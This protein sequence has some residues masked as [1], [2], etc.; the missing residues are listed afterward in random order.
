MN[1]REGLVGDFGQ[2]VGRRLE[3][4]RRLLGQH[5]NAV[6]RGP[7]EREDEVARRERGVDHDPR[8]HPEGKMD[9]RRDVPAREEG[10]ALERVLPV[11]PIDELVQVLDQGRD[12]ALLE[13]AVEA[14][15]PL[16]HE[17][18]D[19]DPILLVRRGR[20]VGGSEQG[21]RRVIAAGSGG[22][23]TRCDRSWVT[24]LFR[25]GSEDVRPQPV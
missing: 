23:S 16:R 5:E 24:F 17:I 6:A 9:R 4:P 20:P 8:L 10:Q 3:Q 7:V 1:H 2:D 15:Q 13:L 25:V 22:A 18:L 11:H 14:L 21:D 12:F 19:D